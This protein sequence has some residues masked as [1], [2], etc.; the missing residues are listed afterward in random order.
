M[1]LE[2]GAG[3]ENWQNFMDADLGGSARQKTMKDVLFE[4]ATPAPGRRGKGYDAVWPLGLPRT[5]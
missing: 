4:G 2:T 5:S 3:R 1:L